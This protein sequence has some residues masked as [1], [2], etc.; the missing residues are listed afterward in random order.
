MKKIKRILV[1]GAGGPAAFNFV[2]SLRVAPERFYIVGTDIK[3]YHLELND[4]D[5]RY[6]IP[7]ASSTDYLKYLN[8]I[9]EK[10]KID[11]IHPQPDVE[12]AFLSENREKIKAKLFLPDK[13]TI[14]LCQDKFE[15]YEIL[16]QNKIPV[17]ESY[18]IE[19]KNDLKLAFKMFSKNN[20][21]MWIRAIKG[22]G[23]RA[24]LPIKE[25]EHAEIWIDYWQKMKGIGYGQF[26][27]SEFLPG[28]EFAFQSLWKDGELITSQARERIEYLFGN[29]TPSGQT[30]T[31]SIA[32]TVHRNDVNKIATAAIKAIDPKASGIFCVDLKENKEGIPCITEINTGRF[33]TTSYFFTQAGLNMPYFYIKLAF[34]EKLPKLK[35]YN[36]LPKDVYWVRHVDMGYKLIKEDQWRSKQLRL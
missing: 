26:M 15:T 8:K 2:K 18:L 22:A 29:I 14:K 12:V 34:N 24:A 10:E 9:I 27:I 16:K 4:L 5:K 7:P 11:F 33:F 13:N 21:L 23:S 30:S 20:K 6:I 31:P 32:K 28:K 3:P 1:T 35:K 25:I 36:P 19:N 17:A